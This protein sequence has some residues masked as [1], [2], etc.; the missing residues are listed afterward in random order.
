[1]ENSKI[2]LKE[3]ISYDPIF[4]DKIKRFKCG[5]SGNFITSENSRRTC[6]VCF[7]NGY[8]KI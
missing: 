1:M 3:I 5:G 7:G 4:I 8:I 2:A 6:L